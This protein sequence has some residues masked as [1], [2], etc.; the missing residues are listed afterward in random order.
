MSDLTQFQTEVRA[1]LEDNCPD[2][3]RT[4]MTEAE[5]VWGGRGET[6]TNPDSKWPSGAGPAPPGR[7]STGAVA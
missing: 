7:R 1:W 2:A 6:F 4:P 5:T 3:M